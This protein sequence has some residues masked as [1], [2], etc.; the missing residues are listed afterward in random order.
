MVAH[1][2]YVYCFARHTLHRRI[3]ALCSLLIQDDGRL[4][5]ACCDHHPSTVVSGGVLP[6]VPPTQCA[7]LFGCGIKTCHWSV[8][9]LVQQCISDAN[10][11]N[12]SM[13]GWVSFGA[14]PIAWCL[15]S[16][17]KVD[18]HACH[19]EAARVNKSRG[20]SSGMCCYLARASPGLAPVHL[21]V[22]AL[23]RPADSGA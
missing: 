10:A 19:N 12:K 17:H 18:N 13:S 7:C 9:C 23:M 4:P 5:V 8:F 22:T 11:L 15:F 21:F 14:L 3:R 16:V 2:L 20:L 6:L 1:S